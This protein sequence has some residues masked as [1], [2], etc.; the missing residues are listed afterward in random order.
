MEEEWRGRP[1]LRLRDLERFTGPFTV[2]ADPGS[3]APAFGVSK[4]QKVQVE[5]SRGGLLLASRVP[6][7][8]VGKIQLWNEGFCCHSSSGH[9]G[10]SFALADDTGVGCC[11]LRNVDQC[12]LGSKVV[13]TSF[14]YI[15]SIRKL[16]P[17]KAREDCLSVCLEVH[18]LHVVQDG[19]ILQVFP[20]LCL[21]PASADVK[22]E[23]LETP[24][25]KR[26]GGKARLTLRGCL[27]C[28]SPSFALPCTGSTFSMAKSLF[29]GGEKGD[30][31]VLKGFLV[32]LR[33]CSHQRLRSKKD[34]EEDGQLV[35]VFFSGA[36]SA[37]RPVLLDCVGSW[38]CI[39]GLRKKMISV[40]P[41]DLHL[42]LAAT[43]T[44]FVSR[45]PDELE[46]PR[47]LR[48]D[49]VRDKKTFGSYVGVVTGVQFE[50]RMVEL[51]ENVCLLLTH[52]E[53]TFLHGLRVGATILALNVHI[54]AVGWGWRKYL[55]LGACFRSTVKI[56][57]FSSLDTVISVPVRTACLSK[58]QHL[59]F[60]ETFGLLRAVLDLRKKLGS[61][62]D[63]F[64]CI[65]TTST[66]VSRD[67]LKE[68]MSHEQSCFLGQRGN[69]KSSLQRIP[70]FLELKEYLQ[71]LWED[72]SSFIW[73]QKQHSNRFN[74]CIIS[75]DDLNFVVLGRLEVS[76]TSGALQF[77]D[78]THEIHVVIPDLHCSSML[79]QVYKVSKFDL[80]MEGTPGSCHFYFVFSSKDAYRC[81][82]LGCEI[83]KSSPHWISSLPNLPPSPSS[84]IS[85]RAR[86]VAVSKLVLVW[87]KWLG[88][89]PAKSLVSNIN[90]SFGCFVIDDGSGVTECSA[91]GVL[92]DHLL[93]LKFDR[94][95]CVT[96]HTNALCAIL[97][98]YERIVYERDQRKDFSQ[99][100][101]VLG[102]GSTPLSESDHAVIDMFATR[103]C[104]RPPMSLVCEICPREFDNKARVLVRSVEE[105][106]YVREA[107]NLS[108]EIELALNKNKVL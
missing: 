56:V 102:D 85:F 7:V 71:Q 16:K 4:R 96:R 57:C 47:S 64:D 13:I 41:K 34:A 99:S 105:I 55:L 39:T 36:L 23:M 94:D 98:N 100:Y 2:A 80:V 11:L 51:D 90:V 10:D 49:L 81:S 14:N 67:G 63:V 1:R 42:I 43:R 101:R 70:P 18:E 9:S 108:K 53:H 83:P 6:W 87:N 44:T 75:S 78:A 15:P 12:P 28:F 26:S 19:S 30:G 45:T 65:Q 52:Q 29:A 40:G 66:R 21:S 3:D 62:P 20:R 46:R 91:H 60:T 86:V 76:K 59:S 103:A 82:A 54:A 50:G 97:R 38:I 27:H 17:E 24:P 37:W 89:T 58:F 74:R 104:H 33:N 22:N 95:Q 106:S 5:E 69:I 77:F 92:A 88:Y 79:Y 73:Q 31:Q 107:H 72:S 48:S 61:G 84:T 68:F 93:G 25:L 32:E 35:R 8:I